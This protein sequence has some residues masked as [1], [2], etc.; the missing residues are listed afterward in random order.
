MKIYAICGF[1]GSGKDTLANL[2]KEYYEIYQMNVVKLSFAKVLKDIV[3]L[4]F[5][6]DR[7]LLEGDTKESRIWREKVDEWWSKRLNIHN[8][9][10]RYILQNWGTEVLRNNFHPDIWIA[11]LENQLRFSGADIILITDCRFENEIE[12]LRNFN[13]KFIWIQ[14]GDNPRWVK[15]YIQE[16]VIP[17]NIHPSEYSWLKNEFD[18]II[19]NDKDI[20]HLKNKI[21]NLLK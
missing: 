8:L 3:A 1:V 4:V 19:E 13:T 18:F 12:T 7:S 6:W 9:T 17:K 16:D 2:I 20:N 10:P 14:R 11:C 21:F 5:N 15:D